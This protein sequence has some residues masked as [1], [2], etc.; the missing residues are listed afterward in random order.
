MKYVFSEQFEAGAS[1]RLA[2][3][4]AMSGTAENPLF[5]ALPSIPDAG[6][7]PGPLKS[8]FDRDVTWPLWIGGGIIYKPTTCLTLALDDQYSQ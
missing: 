5:P 3:K 7:M 6:I 1:F 2:T 8:D 4:V